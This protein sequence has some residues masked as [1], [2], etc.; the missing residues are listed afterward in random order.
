[1]KLINKL[2]KKLPPLA[3]VATINGEI[4]ELVHGEHVDVKENFF[5]EGAWNGEFNKGLFANA[6]WFCGT[7]GYR[8]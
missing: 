4:T 8:K 7:G 6:E 1:M 2:N 3:W 5:V